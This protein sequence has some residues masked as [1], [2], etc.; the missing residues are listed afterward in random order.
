MGTEKFCLKWN[1]FESN[2]SLAF[3]EIRDE[4]DFFDVT[5]ACDDDQLQA[6]K[7]ILSACSPFF[8]NILKRNPHQHP[9]LYLKGVKYS[10]LQSVLNFMYHGEVNVAQDELNSFLAV[11]EELRVKGLTQNNSG[12]TKKENSAPKSPPSKSR[13]SESAAPAPKRPR[14]NPPA[15]AFIQDD[16]I[17]EVVPV[18]SE[19]R[20]IASVPSDPYSN[21]TAIATSN[22]HQL[23]TEEDAYEDNYEDYEGYDQ[24]YDSTMMDPN[25]TGDGNKGMKLEDLELNLENLISKTG[26]GYSCNQC[27]KHCLDRTAARNHVEALHF[28]SKG[29]T[30]PMCGKFMKTKNALNNHVYRHHKNPGLN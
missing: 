28:P 9:L 20:D 1:D 26:S 4:K 29:H 22:Q 18:K 10:D 13:A 6:H 11:A 24:S 2:I 21:N 30:C 3:R 17:Q 23:Q 15:P 7:V 14:P 8:R 19:P 12:S 27:G 5:L 16:D 25:M